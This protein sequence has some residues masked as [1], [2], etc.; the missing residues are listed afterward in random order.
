[1]FFEVREKVK[2]ELF[3]M[4]KRCGEKEGANHMN[5]IPVNTVNPLLTL[6][7]HGQSVWLDNI[8]RNLNTSGELKRLIEE[9]GLC[10]ITS[11][12]AIFEKAINGSSD[13]KKALEELT[14]EQ[15]MD[16]K[17][18]YEQVA[19]WDIRE[20]ADVLKTIYE[21]TKKRD[22][23]VSWEVSP[24]LA[25]DTRGTLEEARRLWKAVG[26]DNIMIKV[27]AT[28]EG[29]LAITQLISDG[30]NVN[31]TL[32]FALET[33]EQVA[34]A[35][36]TGLEKLLERGGD[37]NGVASVA[38]FFISRIDTA[39]DAVI[40]SQLK[41]VRNEAA[42]AALRHLQ[43]K[44]AIAQAKLTYQRY[45]TLFS[46]LRWD[47]LAQRGAM[48]QRLLWASTSAK[49]PKY[50][51][52]IYVEELIGPDTINTIPPATL[53]AFRDHGHPRTRLIE[54]LED[55]QDTMETLKGVGISIQDITKRL[56]REGLQSFTDAFDKLLAA[57][58]QPF[59]ADGPG[60]EKEDS[61]P[62]PTYSTISRKEGFENV[63][64]PLQAM[65]DPSLPW[66]SRSAK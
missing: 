36:L 7:K 43:G 56:L 27:P 40:S 62:L 10:G 16:A 28:P 23:Y 20:A 21:S 13:Y 52:V 47:A 58:E 63:A 9:D 24:H 22:G 64:Q 25:R 3:G 42:Q 5:R 51:D 54:G 19:I 37:I 30:I 50:R 26:R 1:M 14:R 18:R 39:I 41:L 6:Q 29:I 15:D 65:A 53:E 17:T 38:S 59:D 55:A 11:N 31:V 2:T 49:N 61:D 60:I 33:Y 48:T 8:Q 46:S 45:L 32:L 44:I 12:P 57:I 66:Q 4:E 35:Y 34:E